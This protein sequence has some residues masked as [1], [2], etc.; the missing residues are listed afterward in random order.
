MPEPTTSTAVVTIAAGLAVIEATTGVSPPLAVWGAVGGYW[1]FRYLPPMTVAERC[2]SLVIAALIAA[3]G[4]W[5]IAAIGVAAARNF[6][7]WWPA[8]VD[9]ALMSKPLAATLGLL[10]HRVIGKK[11]IEVAERTSD[12]VG[13]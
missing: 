11:L 7:T 9:A 3:I 2:V 10:C 12:G 13:K 4:S 1:A 8:T 6:L 5:P